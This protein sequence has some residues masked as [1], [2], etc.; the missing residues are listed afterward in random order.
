[1]SKAKIIAMVS[2]KGG[3]GKNDILPESCLW[4]V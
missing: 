4:P 1:M 3:D 2:N